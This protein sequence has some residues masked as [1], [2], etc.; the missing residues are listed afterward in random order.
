MSN[1]AIIGSGVVGQATGKGFSKL[2]HSV[3]FVDI[4]QNVISKLSSQGYKVCH[5]NEIQNI[6]Y[7]AAIICLPTPSKKGTI[8]LSY[9]K[10]TLPHL[11]SK[12]SLSDEYHLFVIRSTI[13]PGTTE[14]SLIPILEQTS[15]KK[16]GIDFGICYNPEFLREAYSNEDFLHPN[17][18][19]IGSSDIRAKDSLLKLYDEIINNNQVQITTTDLK[20]SE[21]IKYASNLFSATKISFTNE[22]WNIC[23]KLNINC[24]DVME[25]A[26][27]SSRGML[28]PQYGIKGGYSFGGSCFPK[29]TE[30][31]LTFAN[32]DCGLEMPLLKS[33]IQINNSFIQNR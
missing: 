26:A 7:D 15:G 12:I 14:S 11:G 2:G 30:C 17:S 4:N 24:D 19:I 21:M 13:L 18:I 25:A 23:Q 31:F 10:Y 9:F 16:S 33:T 32:K 22:I 1:L 28:D 8:D 29:D 5:I 20:T 6:H 27:N 3:V